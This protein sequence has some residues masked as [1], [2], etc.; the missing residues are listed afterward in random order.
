LKPE[1]SKNLDFGL[2][3]TPLQR[4]N[5][6]VDAYRID[7]TNRIIDTG[8][9]GGPTSSVATNTLVS[10]ALA[11]NG[12]VVTPGSL[13][14]VQFFTN[15]VDT[16]TRGV[17]FSADYAQYFG[18][19]DKILWFLDGNFN[20]TSITNVHTPPATLA[21][22]GISYL[23]PAVTNDI[24]EATP[25]SRITLA[26]NYR[27][28][29]WDF[30][31]RETRY[32]YTSDISPTAQ[33]VGTK[34]SIQPAYIADADIGYYLSKGIKLSIGGNNIFDNLPSTPPAAAMNARLPDRYPFNTPWTNIG[35]FF[36]VKLVAAF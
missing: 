32:G 22:A 30:T 36:Y 26:A 31:A 20:H 5:L 33:V 16:Q 25:A 7:L 24:T 8:Y 29:N 2:V 9:I 12:N 6:T 13:G 34:V 14:E 15:G 10:A 18:Q 19:G 28:G 35:A 4:L 27:K 3:A 23:S 1:K 21:A 17:D 11:A